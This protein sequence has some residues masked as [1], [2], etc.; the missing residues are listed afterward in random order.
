MF[1]PKNPIQLKSKSIANVNVAGALVG[2]V[3]FNEMLIQQYGRSIMR[4]SKAI[5]RTLRLSTI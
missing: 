3:C 2:S 5:N 4:Q 1:F